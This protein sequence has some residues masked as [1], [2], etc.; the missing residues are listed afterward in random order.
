M[1]RQQFISYVA[2]PSMLSAETE[3]LLGNI[4]REFP[5]FQTAQLLYAKNLFD[6]RSIQYGTQLKIASAYSGNR[7]VLYELISRKPLIPEPQAEMTVEAQLAEATEPQHP[8]REVSLLYSVETGEVAEGIANL[9]AE[10]IDA[11]VEMEMSRLVQEVRLI[12]PEPSSRKSE[13]EAEI[14]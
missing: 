14:Q 13:A 12:K 11:S 1:N 4:V 5:F 2:Q 3:A 9:S 10:A 8:V 7:S 6:I